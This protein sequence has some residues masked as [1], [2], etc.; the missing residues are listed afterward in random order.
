MTNIIIPNGLMFVTFCM[1]SLSKCVADIETL[2]V[3]D[4]D[5][6]LKCC[7]VLLR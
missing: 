6:V 2:R 3:K 5:Q 7:Q 1:A 4:Y